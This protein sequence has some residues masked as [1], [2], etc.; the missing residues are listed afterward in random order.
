M[1]TRQPNEPIV[2]KIELVPPGPPKPM[3]EMMKPETTGE[4]PVDIMAEF[5]RLHASLETIHEQNRQLL[6]R[7]DLM[8][9]EGLPKRGRRLIG[10]F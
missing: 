9:K 10:P 1:T 5:G 7:L 8:Q 6:E 3:S 4:I 2:G